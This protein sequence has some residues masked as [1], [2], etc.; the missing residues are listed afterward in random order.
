MPFFHL[1]ML[2]A[3]ALGLLPT[4]SEL[5]S[6]VF[7]SMGFTMRIQW[8]HHI[9]T[10]IMGYAFI[11]FIRFVTYKERLMRPPCHCLNRSRL[12]S[13]SVPNEVSSSHLTRHQYTRLCFWNPWSYPI[14][15]ADSHQCTWHCHRNFNYNC[16]TILYGENCTHRNCTNH[17]C[18]DLFAPPTS[19]I[20]SL[21]SHISF[22]SSASLTSSHLSASP[23]YYFA[24]L[25]TRAASPPPYVY[26]NRLPSPGPPRVPPGELVD[27][28][29][30]SNAMLFLEY[31]FITIHWREFS[32]QECARAHPNWHV[33]RRLHHDDQPSHL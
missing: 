23:E 29:F 24:P 25:H 16:C 17:H 5:L 3:L 14:Y 9:H 4:M 33:L 30:L 28:E 8:Y 22:L 2:D 21:A 31:K 20:N 10:L 11:L 6:L 7:A 12:E 26:S 32:G 13:R 18:P 15:R 27:G 19:Y 1:V